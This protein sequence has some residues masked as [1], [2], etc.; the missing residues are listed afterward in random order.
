MTDTEYVNASIVFA[1]AAAHEAAD[2]IRTTDC[3]DV[4]RIIAIANAAQ[5]DGLCK[6]VY[7]IHKTDFGSVHVVLWQNAYRAVNDALVA[8]DRAR[9]LRVATREA[10]AVAVDA[11]HAA[12]ACRKAYAL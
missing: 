9:T 10:V 7:A 1:C 11:V 12:E 5:D 6:V 2:A 8:S 4:E 3:E